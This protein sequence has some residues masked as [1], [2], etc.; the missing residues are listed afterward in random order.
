MGRPCGKAIVIG[1]IT[2][3]RSVYVIRI[4]TAANC[5]QTYLDVVLVIV[6]IV[7]L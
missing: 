4:S 5:L 3:V 6:N 2:I 1:I 7:I